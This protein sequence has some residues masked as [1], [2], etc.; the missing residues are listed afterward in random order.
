MD[1]GCC[2]LQGIIEMR[3]KGVFGAAL[4]KKKRYWPKLIP[5]D[6]LD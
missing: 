5:G 4:I 1:S 2:I 6:E 3:K